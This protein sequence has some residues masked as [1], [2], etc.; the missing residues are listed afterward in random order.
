MASFDIETAETLREVPRSAWDSLSGTD[1]LYLSHGWLSHVEQEE[2][3]DTGYLLAS[4]PDGLLG[5][6]PTYAVETE[7]NEDYWHAAALG[8]AGHGCYL[9]AGTRRA[10]VNNFLLSPEL[11]GAQGDDVVDALLRRAE[12]QAAEL[13]RDG[14]ALLYLST[15]A[16]QRLWRIR[17]D[18]RPL[19]LD[20]ETELALAG[21]QFDDYLA[22]VGPRRSYSVRKEI[23]LFAAAGYENAVEKLSQCWHEAGPLVSQVQRKYGHPDTAETCRAALRGLAEAFD[24]QSVVFSARRGGRLVGCAVYFAWR[25]TLH[26]RTVGFAYDELKDLGE[27]FNL[28]IYE[29]V[30]HAYRHQYSRLHLGR[31]SNTAKLRRGAH[32]RALWAVF[33]PANETPADWRRFNRTALRALQR[34]ARLDD[35]DVPGAWVA[36]ETS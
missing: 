32:P 9:V 13:D 10:Y 27:Y 1:S 2:G 12:R 30:R 34:Q 7:T 24:P 23:R 8:G 17:D 16:V 22:A 19:L 11:A 18:V 26:G 25:G 35:L 28:Y 20:I 33:L 15:A 14:V 6:L 4:G 29:P 31:G 21:D 3:A 5:A 36:D